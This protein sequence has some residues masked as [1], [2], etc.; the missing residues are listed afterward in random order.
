MIADIFSILD[1]EWWMDENNNAIQIVDSIL[2]LFMAIP[3][4][5]LFIC[6]LFSLGK[7]QNPYPEAKIKHRF[8]VL[9]TVLR[10]GKEVIHSV[11][12]FL[13]TQNYPRDKYDIAVAATQLPEEDLV[14][15]LQMPVNIVVPDKEKCT[16]VYAVQQVMERYSPNEYDMVILFNSDNRIV[17]SALSLFN[18]AYYSGC[19][20]IQAHRMTENLTT[21]IAILNAT[22]EEINNNIFRKGHTKLGFSAALIGSAMAFDFE[23][24]HKIAPTLK[25]SDM[26]KAVETALLKENIYTEYLEEVVCYSKKEENT[27]GYEAQRIGWL[28]SQ[29]SS[30]IFALKRLPLALLQGKWDYCNKLFQWLLPS[31]FL[32]IAYII[33]ISIGMTVLD[34]PLSI[35]WY[36]LLAVIG[37]TF[38]MALPDGEISKRFRK[39]IWALPL[40]IFT[41]IFSHITR[42]FKKEKR[43]NVA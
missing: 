19:D 37:I 7:Y 11:N 13:D 26:S 17:P 1:P 24:F 36:T 8:L 34:W 31:R 15:L 33:L 4:L 35:K 42:F 39:A 23:M 27:D 41:S 14:T 6:S 32:L 30:T 18:N 28:R 10:N 3:V 16:K 20:A 40:L 9:F 22:S 25:G 38:L 12:N 43:K 5:Y 29:Y 21:S 2:F